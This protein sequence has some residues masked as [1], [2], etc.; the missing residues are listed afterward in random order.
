MI[1]EYIVDE[2]LIKVGSEYIWLWVAIEPNNKQI[3]ALFYFQ[4]KKHVCCEHFLSNLV[5]ILE[6]IQSQQ[7]EAHGTQWPVGFLD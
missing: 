7:M 5:K 2:M 6:S 4:G 3:L 1:S